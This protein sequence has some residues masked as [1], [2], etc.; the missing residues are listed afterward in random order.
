M[1]RNSRFLRPGYLANLLGTASFAAISLGSA[2]LGQTVNLSI[3]GGGFTVADV[4]DRG[5][6]SVSPQQFS[7]NITA[8]I[9]DGAL[10]QRA[11]GA[12]DDSSVV[13]EANQLLARAFGNQ[14]DM[15]AQ[16]LGDGENG[17]LGMLSGQDARGTVTANVNN[18]TL[19][20]EITTVDNASGSSLSASGNRLEAA[21]TVN[22]ARAVFA[23][24][25]SAELVEQL[26]SDTTALTTVRLTGG[27]FNGPLLFVSGGSSVVASSQVIRDGAL[28]SS[29][30]VNDSTIA[31]DLR[32]GGNISAGTD[33]TLSVDG[34][35]LRATLTGNTAVVGTDLSVDTLFQGSAAVLN[36]QRIGDGNGTIGLGATVNTSSL[37]VSLG[38]TTDSSVTVSDNRIGA[39]ANGIVSTNG[40]GPGT[41]LIVEANQIDAAGGGGGGAQFNSTEADVL[42]LIRGAF[43]LGTQQVIAGD[44]GTNSAIT[45]Q[46]L[47]SGLTVTSQAVTDSALDVSGNTLF[48]TS[49]GTEGASEIRISGTA[50]NASAVLGN[51]Q[52]VTNTSIRATLG[53]S[54]LSAAIE[55]ALSGSSVAVDGNLMLT[56]A[57]ANVGRNLLSVQSDTS[58]ADPVATNRLQLFSNGG[59]A[60]GGFVLGSVQDFSGANAEVTAGAN[61][62]VGTNISSGAIGGSRVSVDGNRQ[63]VMAEVNQVTNSLELSAV[64]L[65][66]PDNAV[67]GASAIISSIQNIDASRIQAQSDLVMNVSR[68]GS[69]GGQAAISDS[70]ITIDGNENRSVV[71][72]NEA[73]NLLQMQSETDIQGAADNENIFAN[74]SPTTEPLRALSGINNLQTLDAQLISNA[75]TTARVVSGGPGNPDGV[76]DS[77][78]S[79]SDNLTLSQLSGNVSSSILRQDAGTVSTGTAM[80][81]NVQRAEPAT[82]SIS[83]ASGVFGINPRGNVTG[84]TLAIDANRIFAGATMN[85]ATNT[86]GISATEFES[87]GD[88][89]APRRAQVG[90]A[91]PGGAGLFADFGILSDQSVIGPVEARAQIAGEI[92]IQPSGV[93]STIS[94]SRVSIDDTLVRADA[95]ANRVNNRLNI[96]IGTTT[97]NM[98]AAIV[99][100]Q[101]SEGPIVASTESSG[102]NFRIQTRASIADSSA[103]IDGT[104][105]I[106]TAGANIADNRLRVE[107]TGLDGA[108]SSANFE[109]VGTRFNT[110]GVLASATSD[111]SI[112]N[113]QASD[114]AITAKTEIEARITTLEGAALRSSVSLSDSVLQS[115]AVGNR[116]N[117]LVEL[118]A[119][120]SVTGSAAIANLQSSLANLIAESDMLQRIVLGGQRVVDGIVLEASSARIDDNVA[121][122]SASANIGSSVLSVVASTIEGISSNANN[123]EVFIAGTGVVSAIADFSVGSQQRAESSVNSDVNMSLAQA[124]RGDILT[125]AASISGNIGQSIANVNQ[126]TNTINLQAGVSVSGTAALVNDQTGS[127]SAESE[128]QMVLLLRQNL[129]EATAEPSVTESSMNVEDNLSISSARGNDAVNTVSI[130]GASVSGRNNASELTISGAT[131]TGSNTS[132]NLLATSQTRTAVA[133]VSAA[134]SVDVSILRSSNNGTVNESDVGTPSSLTDS[135]VSISR[136]VADSTANANRVRNTLALNADTGVSAGGGIVS[137]QSSD[138]TVSSDVRITARV[139]SDDFGAISGSSVA[140][141]SNIGVAR[142]SGNDATSRMTVQSGTGV[143]GRSTSGGSASLNGTTGVLNASADFAMLTNQVNTGS[144]TA[145]AGDTSSDRSLISATTAAGLLNSSVSVSNNA[146]VAD[147]T[148]NRADNRIT[149]SGRPASENVSVAVANRQIATGPVMAQTNAARVT[150]ASAAVTSSAVRVSG[151]QMS[152]GATGNVATTRLTRN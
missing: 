67:L 51:E 21:A 38:A 77:S 45:A 29:A 125:S 149:V 133:T 58:L 7:G 142:A 112:T 19:T 30:T 134:G 69:T 9:L 2:A 74:L 50:I 138:S 93:S 40:T 122:A 86:I 39:S 61:S 148:S 53:A 97:T 128:T 6:I 118:F 43:V 127:G 76:V 88:R 102:S 64:S 15:E 140:L 37:A 91:S 60:L 24:N 55:G 66:D 141:N 46:A 18:S 28:T 146:L 85:E 132:D 3:D 117:N 100:R 94:S 78:L 4:L 103:S 16:L 13:I 106:A 32:E 41:F 124:I 22:Q 47:G 139:G 115:Q 87:L 121:V 131:V 120:A 14:S 44:N 35:I 92:L 49:G 83:T 145:S 63:M 137:T 34:N 89:S 150:V 110:S 52:R 136:N 79:V 107:A 25:V 70:T 108:T 26:A 84:S 113:F 54:T 81:R 73:F 27:V 101:A 111:A 116:A 1:T 109:T 11:T 143:A 57:E 8:S 90:P 144:V 123:A 82:G 114:S 147:A 56:Q 17:R 119:D 152:A 104:A 20:A 36:Q 10:E 98:S 75:T 5:T 33:S 135:S 105:F 62:I 72:G 42:S 48:A 23:D 95:Q 71:S 12:V 129:F 96:E 68:Q 65:R 59:Q 130:A 126:S 99:S 80:L 31:V 151:N